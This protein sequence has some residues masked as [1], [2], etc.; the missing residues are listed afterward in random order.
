[1]RWSRRRS[2]LSI[3]LLTTATLALGFAEVFAAAPPAA[4]GGSFPPALD[5]YVDADIPGL[6]AVLG[7]RIREQPFN[8][9][10]TLIFLAA[11][12]HTFLS[13]RFMAI[14]HRWEHAHEK[15]KAE[16]RVP[17]NSVHHGAELFHFLGEVEAVFGHL[18]GRPGGAI[19]AFFDWETALDYVVAPGQLHRGDVR[20][21]HHDPGL[22][23]ADPQAHR[24]G[25]VADRRAARRLG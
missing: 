13:S 5:S 14:S 3:L 25:D 4:G 21:G 19:V 20:G 6:L 23:P 12:V 1:M 2:T 24:A 7:H 11:I 8:L 22:H 9:V 16:G 15:A 17:R 18:G 10:A